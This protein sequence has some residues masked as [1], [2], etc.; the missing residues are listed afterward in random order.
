MKSLGSGLAIKQEAI[1][2]DLTLCFKLDDPTSWVVLDG[3]EIERMVR[4]HF[5][6]APATE[7]HGISH[8]IHA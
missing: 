2:Q 1:L 8:A 6:Y 5:D 3:S 7:T 4:S